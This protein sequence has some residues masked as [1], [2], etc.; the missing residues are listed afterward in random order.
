MD[1]IMSGTAQVRVIAPPGLPSIKQAKL[2]DTL[3]VLEGEEVVLDCETTGAKPAAEVQWKDQNGKKILANLLETVHIIAKNKTFKTVSTMRMKPTENMN[4]TC[5]AFSDAFIEPR[6]SRKVKIMIKHSPRVSLNIT[7]EGVK[8]GQTLVVKCGCEA[9]P[10]NV[11]YKW[12]LNDDATKETREIFTIENV[13]KELNNVVITCEAE[14]SVG[15]SKVS[16]VLNVNFVPQILTHPVSEIAKYGEKV[17]LSCLAEGNPAP[18]YVWVKGKSQE[19]VGVSENLVLTATDDTEDDYN[20]KVFVDGKKTLISETASLRIMRKPAVFTESVKHAK[21]DDDVILQCRVESLSNN[22]KVTWTKNDEPIDR[23]EVKHRILHT[24]NL[25]QFASDLIIYNVEEDDFTNYGCFSSNEVGTDYK[26]FPLEK[27]EDKND[28][29]S[30][31]LSINTIVG[32]IILVFIIIYHK[33]KNREPERIAIPERLQ[34]QGG[35]EVQNLRREI[36]PPI[37]RAEDPTVFQEP[38]LLREM[39]E[40]YHDMTKEYFNTKCMIKEKDLRIV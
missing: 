40:D 3:H 39:H 18:S 33:R 10:S 36:L 31:A 6:V 14:N 19:I 38:L 34:R 11:T 15:R 20:C 30:M 7:N 5:S 13:S 26:V 1:A 16:K 32:I 37:Y 35:H 9:Y 2:T 27:E 4:L 25:Y 8:M 12:F 23:E 29:I 28:Y 24:D 22:T 17:K 21:I